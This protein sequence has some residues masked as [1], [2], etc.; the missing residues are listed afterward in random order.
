MFTTSEGEERRREMLIWKSG[1]VCAYC[2]D[3]IHLTAEVFLLQ[4]VYSGY[5]E[6]G[7]LNQF[8]L[9]DNEGDYIYEPQFFHL[10]CWEDLWENFEAF[11][12]DRPPLMDPEPS[13]QI[14]ECYG[15][16]S[17]IRAYEP[18][19]LLSFGEIRRSRRS[20]DGDTTIYFDPCNNKSETI[21]LTC[22]HLMNNELF[23]MWDD[24]TSNGVCEQGLHERC[25]RNGT[26]TK[27]CWH[28]IA[29]A[30]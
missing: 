30:E 14:A 2:G 10:E 24:L 22:L 27:G 26:C 20:P 6:Q 29:A 16:E 25:W 13:L 9:Q 17:S 4:I 23:E 19:G 11:L 7:N 12:E 18:A 28:H 3:G 21:C 1:H 5:D 15:C 8:I